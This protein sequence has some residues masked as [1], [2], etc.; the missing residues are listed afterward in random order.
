MGR[1]KIGKQT[2]VSTSVKIEPDVKQAIKEIYGNLSSYI[3]FIAK[4]DLKISTRLQE[5]RRLEEE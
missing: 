3:A 1:K 5:I 4:K 2:R